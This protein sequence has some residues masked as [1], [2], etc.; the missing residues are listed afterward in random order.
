[1]SA[2]HVEMLSKVHLFAG[3]APDA[4]LAIA[5]ITTEETHA[6]GEKIFEHGDPGDKLYLIL[7][8]KVR[9]SRDVPGMGEEA[10]AVLGPGDVFGEMC[11]FE[12]AP[13][14]AD[15]RVHS[16]VHG[17][18]DEP[19]SFLRSPVSANGSGTRHSLER[20]AHS[21][22]AP[23]RDERQAYLS[24]GQLQVHL[25]MSRT[26]AFRVLVLLL[27]LG[28][29]APMSRPWLRTFARRRGVVVPSLRGLRAELDRQALRGLRL[30][31]S[32][33]CAPTSIRSASGRRAARL[34]LRGIVR[35]SV[36]P[37]IA[38]N[39]HHSAERGGHHLLSLRCGPRVSG[40]Q[41]G[42]LSLTVAAAYER[43]VF[44]F[45]AESP[46]RREVPTAR[47]SLARAGPTLA[48]LSD[49]WLSSEALRSCCPSRSARS[50]I[51][52]PTGIGFGARAKLGV[53]V[54]LFPMLAI[55]LGGTYTA[56]TFH[57]PSVPGRSDAQEPCSIS[58]SGPASGSP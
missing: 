23:A 18:V 20:G 3:L 58:I 38:R 29:F 10:L 17:A 19:G 15:A 55:D 54:D 42:P 8:G 24:F 30:S 45:D 27:S 34:R 41:S 6:L 5:S 14:S 2:A 7:D 37:K 48:L 1:M 50:A 47:Y 28:V 13:R 26:W 35:T 44:D 25:S 32:R 52:D 4:L 57:L 49:R 53:A 40:S 56:V 39:R 16:R 46:P 11:L 21:L 12:E 9:I 51:A 31:S 33:T 22:Q 43:W 36:R